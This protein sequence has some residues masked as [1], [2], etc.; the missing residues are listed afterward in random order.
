MPALAGQHQRG[1]LGQFRR[2]GRSR[3]LRALDRL[4]LGPATLGVGAIELLRDLGGPVPI[5]GQHELHPGVGS[6]QAARGV[7]ARCE[8]E[9]ERA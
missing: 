2:E 8:A 4:P 6:I 3:P 7:D 1:S 9:S 5:L